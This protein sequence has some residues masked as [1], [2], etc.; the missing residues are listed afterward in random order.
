MKK[1]L[2]L[3]VLV[4]AVGGLFGAGAAVAAGRATHDP[5]P[6]AASTE[7]VNLA[8]APTTRVAVWVDGTGSGSY[9]VM[10]GRRISAVTNPL[11]G[12]WCIRANVPGFHPTNVIPTVSFEHSLSETNT[13]AAQWRSGRPHCPA[14]TLEVQTFDTGTGNPDNT[15]AFTV[16]IP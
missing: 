1:T 3:L 9:T 15:V 5:A 7:G 13:A 10:R 8:E 6:E 16:L 4:A 14:G 2:V 11:D 12:S